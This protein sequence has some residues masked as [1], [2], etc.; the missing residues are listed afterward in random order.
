MARGNHDRNLLPAEAGIGGAC[1]R[2][3]LP[4]TGQVCQATNPAGL[5]GPQ[6]EEATRT[7]PPSSDI[8]CDGETNAWPILPARP[9]PAL[10]PDLTTEYRLIKYSSPEPARTRPVSP[11]WQGP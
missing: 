8:I 7:L 2:G 9:R 5:R 1:T 11:T 6:E 3:S 4:L 10:D